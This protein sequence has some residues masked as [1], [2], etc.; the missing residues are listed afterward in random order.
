MQLRLHVCS[1]VLAR[2]VAF[3]DDVI[4]HREILT[5]EVPFQHILHPGRIP[6]LYQIMPETCLLLHLPRHSS[7]Q[8]CST[9]NDD[10]AST[11]LAINGGAGDVRG[12]GVVGH[13]APRVVLGRRLRVPHIAA[14][15]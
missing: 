7:P 13:V 4:L 10:L 14:V 11:D 9:K 8:L 2:E 6:Q 3:L 15:S 1:L 5:L 12:H